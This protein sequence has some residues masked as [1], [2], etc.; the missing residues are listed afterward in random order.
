M[1]AVPD[2]FRLARSAGLSPRWR[3]RRRL[4]R[5]RAERAATP[6][7]MHRAARARRGLT[8]RSSACREQHRRRPAAQDRR[9][10]L[11][12]DRRRRRELAGDD[13]SEP[14]R[15]RAEGAASRACRSRCSTS[16][17][18]G[19]EA[20][21]HAGALRR[22]VFAENPDLV[23]W[24]VGSNS[25]LRDQPTPARPTSAARGLERLQGERHRRDP[26]QSAIRA[27]DHRQA[28]RRRAWSIVIDGDRA[29]EANVDLF[30]RFAVMRY[31]RESEDIPF[32]HVPVAGRAAHERLELWLHRQAAG[33][34][35]PRSGDARRP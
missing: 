21:R 22:D 9:H 1:K 31:W 13:L 26:D 15:G 25:V 11:V 4:L 30:H 32:E 17:I 14:A 10:R 35:D 16:G 12:L 18:N 8:I 2:F 3:H 33:R 27:E 24:Q 5:R 23:L 19:E 29:S 34:R 20:A 6:K 28:R 7:P